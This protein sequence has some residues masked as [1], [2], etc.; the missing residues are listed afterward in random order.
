MKVT[1]WRRKLAAALVAGGLMSPHE[2]WSADLNVNLIPDPQF[3]MLTDPPVPCCFGQSQ[4]DSWNDGTQPGFA[5]N[6]TISLYD[7]GGPLA[8]GGAHYFGTARYTGETLPDITMPGMVS[9]NLDVSTG[10]T[11]AQIDS[12]EAVAR[13]SAYFTSYGA[14]Q[15]THNTEGDIGFV[16]V[17]FLN[18]SA[19]SLGTA[20]ISRRQPTVNGW[21]QNT[22]AFPIPVATRTLKVSLY[23]AAAT[24]GPDGYI[25]IVDVQVRDAE[26]ELLFLEIASDGQAAIRNNS[27]EQIHIDYYEITSASGALRPNNWSSLQDQNLAGFPAGNGSGNGWEENSGSTTGR[28]GEANLAAYS[29]MANGAD[30]GI[31]DAFNPAGAHDLVFKYSTP[32]ARVLTADFDADG[33]VDG[34]D[35]LVW[36]RGNGTSLGETVTKALGDADSDRDVDGDDL[37]VWR[38]EFGSNPLSSPGKLVTGFVRYLPPATAVPEPAAVWLAGLGAAT[39]AFR[40]RREGTRCGRS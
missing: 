30:I 13:L 2:A 32:A 38:S 7:S 24:T 29:L 27:G 6:N 34:R 18:A 21:D 15:S 19:N 1:N 31:G 26:D 11:L 16:H 4:L 9:E 12:G 28:I 10:V 3:D 8:G 17:D 22:G 36:Q 14:G 39:V 40:G 35:F 33:D 23:G 25:D 37:A 20:Q 5:Y